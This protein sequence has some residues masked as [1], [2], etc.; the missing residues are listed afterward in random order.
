MRSRR[1]ARL[2]A[3]PGHSEGYG[4]EVVQLAAPADTVEISGN[5]MSRFFSVRAIGVAGGANASL[6]STTDLAIGS[7]AIVPRS[8]TTLIV[9]AVGGWT[10]DFAAV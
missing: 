5:L 2:L 7:Q 9:T 6:V 4:D 1:T 3:V 10:L 8:A